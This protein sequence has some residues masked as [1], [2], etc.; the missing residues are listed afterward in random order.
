MTDYV[1]PSNAELA[2]QMSTLLNKWQTYI[3]QQRLRES[4]SVNGGPNGDGY[5]PITDP[6][7]ITTQQPSPARMM[8]I[9]TGYSVQTKTGAGPFLMAAADLGKH[10][11]IGNGTS[12]PNIR[13][14]L[15]NL[16]LGSQMMFEQLGAS[17]LLFAAA[18]G[19]NAGLINRQGFT[20]TAG[21][22]AVAFALVVAVTSGVS[23]WLLGGDMALA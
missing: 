15:P 22:Y 17:R 10:S 3:D 2:Q 12:T 19:S 20:R 21:Q 6:A 9:A 13:I 18:S 5:Y 16:P 23:T 8:Q 7:G 11:R 4:G 1:P 14:D